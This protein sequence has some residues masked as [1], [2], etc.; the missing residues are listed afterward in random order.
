M[1]FLEGAQKC[2]RFGATLWKVNFYIDNLVLTR[3]KQ[4]GCPRKVKKLC[5]YRGISWKNP[6]LL[7]CTQPQHM[8]ITNW[9][10]PRSG[11]SIISRYIRS[12]GSGSDGLSVYRLQIQLWAQAF[13]PVTLVTSVEAVVTSQKLLAYHV[14]RA[15]PRATVPQYCYVRIAICKVTRI[16]AILNAQFYSYFWPLKQSPPR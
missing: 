2:F 9:L 14:P 4:K 16:N 10:L 1:L 13:L 8:K 5:T 6:N 12:D 7:L 11:I 3:A 15:L